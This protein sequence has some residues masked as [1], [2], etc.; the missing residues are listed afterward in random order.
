MS[1]RKYT[2]EFKQQA[3]KLARELGNTTR[4][5]EQLGIGDAIIHTWAKRFDAATGKK[6]E[7]VVS[8]DSDEIKRLKKE[9]EELKK[10]NYILKRAAAFF[11]QD[12]LK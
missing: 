6:I 2:D 10:V 1:K 11:S 12:H 5:A 7:P 3:V 4:A 9:V 8:P